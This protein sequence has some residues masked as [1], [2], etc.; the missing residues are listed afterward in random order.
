M[1]IKTTEL[2]GTALNYAVAIAEGYAKNIAG[3]P[4][5]EAWAHAHS[6]DPVN[7]WED[8]GPIIKRE[9]IGL[10]PMPNG[11]WAAQG[12]FRPFFHNP[13]PEIAACR[14]HVFCKL[15]HEIDIPLEIDNVQVS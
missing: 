15:G 14:C 5:F 13:T 2:K 9:R 6:F 10:T 12:D 3:Y 7:N 11:S 1:K 8:I 4:S